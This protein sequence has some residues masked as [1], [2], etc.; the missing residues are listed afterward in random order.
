MRKLAM[1]DTKFEKTNSTNQRVENENYWN[2]MG[3]P[4]TRP[5]STFT[6]HNSQW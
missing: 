2:I 4:H 3:R 1:N 5:I 6:F